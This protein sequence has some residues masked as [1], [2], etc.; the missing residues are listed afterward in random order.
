[1]KVWLPVGGPPPDPERMPPLAAADA[2]RRAR[3][4]TANTGGLAGREDTALFVE[5]LLNDVCAYCGQRW[6]PIQIDH[7]SGRDGAGAH[8]WD[9]LTAAC[10]PCN[11]IKRQHSVLWM[12]ARMGRLE[13]DG[14]AWHAQEQRLLRARDQSPALEA[15]YLA[16]ATAATAAWDAWV[17]ACRAKEEA[18]RAW[19]AAAEE[20]R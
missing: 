1:M 14:R 7:I 6:N 17:A 9:N 2:R 10:G 12:V 19:R 11:Q 8:D 16:A 20:Y 3:Q 18:E 13:L 5:M 4:W 15:A